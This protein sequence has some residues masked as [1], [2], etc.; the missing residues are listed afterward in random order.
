MVRG[1]FSV[2]YCEN[3]GYQT[4]MSTKLQGCLTEKK[5]KAICFI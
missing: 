4:E 2:T 1:Y 3:M 5:T